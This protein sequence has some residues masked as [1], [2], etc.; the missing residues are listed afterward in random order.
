MFP[1]SSFMRSALKIV[2]GLLLLAA[3]CLASI[4]VGVQPVG[5]T[6]PAT[7][8][9]TASSSNPITGWC[10]YVDSVLV[11]RQNTSA[12]RISDSISMTPGTHQVVVRAWDTTGGFGSAYLTVNIGAYTPSNLTGGGLIPT[13][14]STAR[15]YSNIDNM[16]GW[17]GCT[18]CANGPVAQYWMKQF[19]SSPSLDGT[20]IEAWIGGYVPWA[21]DL[22]VKKF[23]DQDWANHIEYTMSFMWNASRT[24]QSNGAYV[25]QALEFD[26]YF[27]TNGFKYMFGSQC[28]YASGHWD[29]WNNTGRYWQHTEVA[30]NRF[31]P[32]QWHKI[33]W[34]VERDQN[35]KYL[36]YVALQVDNTQYSINT[37]VP[38]VAT[39]WGDDFGVQFQQDTDSAGDPWYEW[40]DKVNA[41]IW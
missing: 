4:S 28:D 10:I 3:P 16:T 37:W 6:S 20:G 36:H 2:S 39:N 15:S 8:V 22:F 9:A 5:S 27:S 35:T 23:G 31:G 40:V 13:P 1:G 34:Y 41:E 18:V 7:I 38:A 19:V 17:I 32:G 11:F 14:P 26:T 21:D 24:R 29:I 33:T 12:V 25:V 30:C